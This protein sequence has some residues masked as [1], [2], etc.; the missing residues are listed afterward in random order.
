MFSF[1][2]SIPVNHSSDGEQTNY[3]MKLTIIK[4][5][6]SNTA[7]TIYLNNHSANW[8]YDI[9]F[10]NADGNILDY[11]REEY[12]ATDMTVW[13]KCDT[14]AASGATNLYLYYGDSEASDESDGNA[15]FV[16]FDGF[17]ST[18][19]DTSKWYRWNTNGTISISGSIA[20][21]VGH[22]SYLTLGSKT[23]VA[24]NHAFRG[25]V[26]INN[27]NP[28]SG[29]DVCILGADER[30]S[31]GS[32]SGG[33]DN[34][35]IQLWAEQKQYLTTKNGAQTINTR[36]SSYTDY[37]TAEIAWLPNSINFFENNS[38]VKNVT[39]NIPADNLGLF[40]YVKDSSRTVYW[41]W[42]LI[43]KLATN[44]PS[45]ATPSSEKT[46]YPEGLLLFPNKYRSTD[47]L[48]YLPSA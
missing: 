21:F 9:Q 17:E 31:S 44:E 48:S 1:Y 12:D 5:T 30:S 18:T 45:W 32:A 36:T 24:T 46:T 40:V 27:D 23:K 39:T 26:K 3:Q 42:V 14:I 2:T 7:G 38:I 16:F 37:I 35:L 22:S 8:P 43:R 34:A 4:G 6:G 13:V 41:D 28:A 10:K 33:I 15:T 47:D 25:R 29:L 19:L 20:T 11:W